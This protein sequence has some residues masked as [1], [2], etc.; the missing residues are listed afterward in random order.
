MNTVLVFMV[1]GSIKAYYIVQ[2]YY[3]RLNTFLLNFR[4]LSVFRTF[5]LFRSEQP[6]LLSCMF[7]LWYYSTAHKNN[8]TSSQS[9]VK[10]SQLFDC[11]LLRFGCRC[12]LSLSKPERTDVRADGTQRSQRQNPGGVV[13]SNVVR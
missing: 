3:H 13:A 12:Q 5:L 11:R 6:Q 4:N 9:A 1:I 8:T 10:S 7:N 2:A